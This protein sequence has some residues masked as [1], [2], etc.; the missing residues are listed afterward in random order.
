MDNRLPLSGETPLSTINRLADA[1]DGDTTAAINRVIELDRG[2]GLELE[3]AINRRVASAIEAAFR[4]G[5]KARE[6]PDFLIFEDNQA[7]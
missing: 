1:E 5:W 2:L 4:L 7:P 6:S 3:D